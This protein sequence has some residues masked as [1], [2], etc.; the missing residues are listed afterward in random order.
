VVEAAGHKA[1]PGSPANRTNRNL[2]GLDHG[3]QRCRACGDCQPVGHR[4]TS[5]PLVGGGSR[6]RCGV[7]AARPPRRHPA[8]SHRLDPG[9]VGFR[10][11]Q[12]SEIYA[13]LAG[14]GRSYLEPTREQTEQTLAQ[15]VKDI[16]DP[17]GELTA[18]C[19]GVSPDRGPVPDVNGI[20]TY[21]DLRI[22]AQID[23]YYRPALPCTP[24]DCD[25][26][27]R[28]ALPCTPRDCDGCRRPNQHWGPGRSSSGCWSPPAT[29][30]PPE[31]GSRSLAARS[32]PASPRTL[33]RPAT[34][35]RSSSPNAPPPARTPA[36][37]LANPGNPP[38]AADRQLRGTISIENQGWLARITDPKPTTST[39]PPAGPPVTQ[40]TLTGCGGVDR[41]SASLSR[42]SRSR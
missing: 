41:A 15:R 24:R 14:S 19:G 3:G 10:S 11:A 16:I 1:G 13:Y 32:P 33:V 23:G 2:L 39:D 5:G 31:A 21:L 17:V 9:Q 36:R 20:D 27:Y 42:S 7:G 34:T 30:P 18:V 26:Y 22:D 25:G 28:P 40:H 8:A 4:H 12:E 29:S 6:G 37:D 35:I 38:G